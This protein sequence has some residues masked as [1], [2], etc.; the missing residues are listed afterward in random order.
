MN[1]LNQALTNVFSKALIVNSN[2]PRYAR[3]SFAELVSATMLTK[4]MVRAIKSAEALFGVTV[5]NKIVKGRLA[6][7]VKATKRH[8]KVQKAVSGTPKAKRGR[9]LGSKNRPKLPLAQS[10]PI[11]D[12]VESI[13]I[14]TAD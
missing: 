11:V 12:T 4:A 1:I 8:A 3:V 2:A 5:E 7:K 10:M 14:A 13:E 6:R 9:P